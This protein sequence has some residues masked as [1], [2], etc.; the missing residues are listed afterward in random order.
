MEI[1][2][3]LGFARGSLIG[4]YAIYELQDMIAIDDFVW[5]DVT[6]F[7][8]GWQADPDIEFG[9]D[10]SVIWKAQRFD[11]LRAELGK[12]LNYD[13]KKVDAAL[14]RVMMAAQKRLNMRVGPR[15]I[16]KLIARQPLPDFPDSP[17]NSIPQWELIK[18]K[19]FVL[20][21]TVPGPELIAKFSG[22][23]WWNAHQAEYPNSARLADLSGTFALDAADFIAELRRAGVSVVV[24][25]TLRNK[26]RA[27]LMFYSFQIA[28]GKIAPEKVPLISGCD[29]IWDHGDP[30]ASRIG[31]QEMVDLFQI[32]FRPSLTSLH[33]K[34]QAIDMTITW[35][36]KIKVA[37]KAGKLHEIA[38]PGNGATSQALHAIGASYRVIKL[39]SDRPHWSST[40]H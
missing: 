5:R 30:D 38:G 16:V 14:G 31:A 17:H 6:K 24:S 10:K 28:H 7:S 11:E 35:A 36:S 15:R 21:A 2:D 40:G 18:P 9:P 19:A 22:A 32:V 39:L 13:E 4:G 3:R 25:A 8:A 12:Q 37:D 1:E 26:T 33:I 27:E 23:K 34:G 20:T 29:I